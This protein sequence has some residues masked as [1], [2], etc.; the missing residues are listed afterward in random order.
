MQQRVASFDVL[1]FLGLAGVIL[2]HVNP[3][4]WVMQ[5]RNFDVVLLVLLSGATAHEASGQRTAAVA[6]LSVWRDRFLRLALPTWVFLLFYFGI[7]ALQGMLTGGGFL[8]STREVV[9]SFTF[10]DGIGYVWIIRLFILLALVT[11]WIVAWDKRCVSHVR[12]VMA[13]FGVLAGYQLLSMAVP[14]TRNEWLDFMLHE[15]LYATL[16]YGAVFALG[17]RLSRLPVRGVVGMSLLAWVVYFGYGI[18]FYENAVWPS[19]NNFKYPPHGYYLSYGLA[20]G[21]LCYVALDRMAWAR[22]VP[23]VVAR[24]GALTMW[25]YLWH[26][27][28]L[29]V[30]SMLTARGLFPAH[31]AVAFGFVWVMSIIATLLQRR[32]LTPFVHRRSSVWRRWLGI[33]LLK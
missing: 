18:S 19:T 21:L 17:V 27:F 28:M 7:I 30:Q 4:G 29:Y 13:C 11:P 14:N 2:A 8:F 3:P 23:P 20:A 31:W 12:Y 33:A 22:W 6:Q 10:G 24:W 5:L 32:V 25:I 16:A 15:V 9:T 1:R 26:I